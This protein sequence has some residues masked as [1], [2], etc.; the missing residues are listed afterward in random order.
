MTNFAIIL[1]RILENSALLV[2]SIIGELLMRVTLGLCPAPCVWV[3]QQHTAFYI[4]EEQAPGVLFIVIV[5]TR[6]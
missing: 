4:N 3:N 1:A 6:P 2:I 5:Q